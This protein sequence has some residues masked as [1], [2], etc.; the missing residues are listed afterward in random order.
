MSL[1]E[2]I[3]YGLV[4]GIAEFLPVSAEAHQA[5]LR[6]LFGVSN[7]SSLQELL[8]HIGVLVSVFVASRETLN[9]LRLAQNSLS[10]TRRRR[11]RNQLDGKS[12]YDLRLVKTAAVPLIIGLFLRIT[13]QSFDG[14]LLAV[15]VFMLLN[16]LVLL[17]VAHSSHGNRDAR[18][19]SGLDGI[20][21]GVAGALS[22]LPGISR[23][24]M[25]A[26]YA[27]VRG[28]DTESAADWAILLGIPAI[29][30]AACLDIVGIFFGGLGALSASMVA[31]CVLSGLTAF[32]GGYLGISVLRLIL[33]HVGYSKFAYYSI[34]TA[35]FS[36]ILYLIA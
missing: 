30:V 19:M 17:L 32:C 29:I 11:A 1:L 8:I 22:V 5:L 6:L 36:F 34:G 28:A 14:N 31:G 25:I 2:S 27:T 24:G 9:R 20:V 12:Y 13:T 35:M 33:N 15:M 7:R 16:A 18:T 4:S 26:S 3:L 21:M 10:H 23:T